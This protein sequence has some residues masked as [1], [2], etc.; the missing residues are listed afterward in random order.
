MSHAEFFHTMQENSFLRAIG[1]IDLDLPESPEK[2]ARPPPQ[3]IDPYLRFVPKQ[4]ISHIFTAPEKRPPEE[5][6]SAFLVLTLLPLVG[7]LIGV[8]LSSSSWKFT[9]NSWFYVI[10]IFLNNMVW[11]S[12]VVVLNPVQYII[13]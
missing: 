12:I 3:P 8:R 9:C 5:L 7:F 6:S 10:I 11:W 4:E 1:H 13:S 2:A